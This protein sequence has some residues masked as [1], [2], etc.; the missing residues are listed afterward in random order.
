M[1]DWLGSREH[2]AVGASLMRR[3][4][5]AAPV[6]FGLGGSDAGRSVIR[7]GGYGPMPPVTVYERVLRPFRLLRTAGASPRE[8]A[9]AVRDVARRLARPALAATVR[10]ELEPVGAFGPEIREVVAAASRHAVVAF[11]TPERLNDM[12]RYPRRSA[13]GYLFQSPGGAL[14]GLAILTT[15]PRGRAALGR[16]VDLLLD[17][18]D[19]ATWHAALLLI[20]AELKRLGADVAQAFASPSWT[21]EA[22][23]R[24]GFVPRHPLEFSL[25]DRRALLPRDVPFYLTPIEADYAFG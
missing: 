3:A 14:R 21:T 6:Q 24:A 11:R 2:R 13:S 9:R 15:L 23:H 12:L 16:V 4:H 10:L 7:R 22:L 17:A 25:R 5:E 19:P 20:S 8:A 18:A 1:I